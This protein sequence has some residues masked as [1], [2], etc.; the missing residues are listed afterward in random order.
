M[1][2]EAPVKRSSRMWLGVG[3]IG[4]VLL[5]YA[6]AHEVRLMTDLPGATPASST[7]VEAPAADTQAPKAAPSSG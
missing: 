6:V 4:L 1:E 5:G 7:P 3:A 2:S